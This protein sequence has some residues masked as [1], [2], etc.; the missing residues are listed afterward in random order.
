MAKFQ[1]YIG[2]KSVVKEKKN[3]QNGRNKDIRTKGVLIPVIFAIVVVLLFF[4]FSSPAT[5]LYPNGNHKDS[6][7]TTAP[8]QTTEYDPNANVQD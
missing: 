4:I 8:T 7:T 1:N 2:R 3:S 5:G 6:L